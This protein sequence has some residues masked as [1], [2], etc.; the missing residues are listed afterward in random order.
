[1]S[2]SIKVV[3]R[4]RGGQEVSPTEEGLTLDSSTLGRLADRGLDN[5]CVLC[6]LER[7]LL[8]VRPEWSDSADA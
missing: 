8:E 6:C 2:E 5:E 7:G 4:F 3:C 1:M